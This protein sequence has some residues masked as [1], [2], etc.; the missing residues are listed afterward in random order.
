METVKTVHPDNPNE[1]RII[2]VTDYDAKKHTLWPGETLPDIP[3]FQERRKKNSNTYYE[4][5]R[6]ETRVQH[7]LNREYSVKSSGII[8]FG[9]AALGVAT[10]LPESLSGLFACILIAVMASSLGVM[11]FLAVKIL[12]PTTWKGPF[13]IP[14]LRESLSHYEPENLLRGMADGHAKAIKSNM[15]VLKSKG[16]NLKWL[17]IVAAIELAAFIVF[18]LCPLWYMMIPNL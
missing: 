2:N 6:D 4:A 9:V 3:L 13:H 10:T 5:C 8:T 17:M 18:L 7:Q 16:K 1:P 12:M 14:D 11:S 15:E